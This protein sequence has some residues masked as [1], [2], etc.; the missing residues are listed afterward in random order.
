MSETQGESAGPRKLFREEAKTGAVQ[1][2]ACGAPIT[3]RGFAGIEQVT[4]AFC[5]TAHQPEPEGALT[6]IQVQTHVA[7]LQRLAHHDCVFALAM[8]GRVIVFAATHPHK[9][10]VLI[11]S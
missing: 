9:T 2:T 3:L 7:T 5:G 6:I 4:C 11:H 1:C 8:V 10:H